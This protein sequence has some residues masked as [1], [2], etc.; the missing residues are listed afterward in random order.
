MAKKKFKI[1]VVIF[2]LYPIFLS[3]NELGRPQGLK[4]EQGGDTYSV[5]ASWSKNVELDMHHYTV[6]RGTRSREYSMTVRVNHP[7]TSAVIGGMIA[8]VTYFF[9]VTAIDTAGNESAFSDE[10]QFVINDTTAFNPEIAD[11][12]D[13]FDMGT[14]EFGTNAANVSTIENG[15]LT[16]R[17]N[18]KEAGWVHT[19]NRFAL[20]NCV[21]E[22]YFSKTGGSCNV[23]FSP[24]VRSE[25]VDG[26]LSEPDM[27]RIYIAYTSQDGRGIYLQEKKA[28][29]MVE[30]ALLIA[31][32]RFKTSPVALRLT[33]SESGMD[34]SYSFDNEFFPVLTRDL[35]DIY[36][37]GSFIELSSYYTVSW[38]EAHVDSFALRQKEVEPNK[39]DFTKDGIV[40]IFDWI[41]LLRHIG[42]NSVS[43]DYRP[44]LDLN[45]DGWIDGMDKALFARSSGFI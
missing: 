31:D 44:E 4:A 10:V 22:V 15:I 39:F 36:R 13:Y 43:P 18:A 23:G 32:T 9:A 33:F 2:M 17:S 5:T 20:R 6:Y 38:E 8:N 12:F 42:T 1:A 28:D 45:E 41:F 30:D 19:V 24:T 14:W 11:G 34:I 37:H 7:D 21:M 3:A 26:I 27:I 35:A 25:S 29:V 40:D 16:L